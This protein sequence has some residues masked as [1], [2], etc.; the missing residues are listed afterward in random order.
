MMHNAIRNVKCLS[1]ICRNTRFESSKYSTTDMAY[2]AYATFYSRGNKFGAAARA[3]ARDK[4]NTEVR[5]PC[6]IPAVFAYRR[7]RSPKRINQKRAA[8]ATAAAMAATASRHDTFRE[9]SGQHANSRE[10]KFDEPTK[11]VSRAK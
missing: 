8:A 2:L 9:V 4:F 6:K 10:S 1:T 11:L 5:R 7:A 3:R